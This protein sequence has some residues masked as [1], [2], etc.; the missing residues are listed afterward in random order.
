MI[1][2]RAFRISY[3]FLAVLGLL[4]AC[5]GG[6]GDKEQNEDSQIAPNPEF[7]RKAEAVSF[8]RIQLFEGHVKEGDRT[9]FE[10]DPDS[11]ESGEL[12][13]V[14]VELE[15]T[16]NLED[17]AVAIQLVPL[18]IFNQLDDGTTLGEIVNENTTIPAGSSLIDLGGAYID[19]IQPGL[20]HAVVHAKLPVLE[21]DSIFKVAV[22][23]SIGQ[24]S[25]GQEI[26]KDDLG[27][28]PVFFDDREL[29]ISKLDEVVVTIF[30]IPELTDDN[31]FTR[32]EVASGFDPEGFSNKP[33]FQTSL[34]VDITT[35]NESEEVVLSLAWQSPGGSPFP[36][37][38]LTSDDDGNPVISTQAHFKI[39]RTDTTS[40][41]IPVVAFTTETTH[42]ALLESA[43]SIRE[44]S[45]KPALSGNFT[46]A[47]GY[48]E[49]DEEVD[50]GN[51]FN[52]SI[53]L[54]SQ[55]TRAQVLAPEQIINFAVL[56][57]GSTNQACLAIPSGA[58]DIDTGFLGI[59]SVNNIIA[60]TCLS[61]PSDAMLWRY[62]IFTRQFISKETDENGDNYCLTAHDVQVIGN[63][64]ARTAEQIPF[65]NFVEMRLKKCE[66]RESTFGDFAAPGTALHEQTFEFEE[67][68]I[69][70]LMNNRY[71]TVTLL[72]TSREDVEL[73]VDSELAKDFSRDASGADVDPNGRLFFIG[74][75][76]E[77]GL[78]NV[79]KARVSLSYG[80]ESYL[81]YKPVLGTTT[82]GHATLSA[83]LFG[84]TVNLLD[85]SFAHKRYLSKQ[86]SAVAGNIHPV[87]VGNGAELKIEFLGFS[88][89]DLGEIET[90]TI[91]ESYNPIENITDM[92]S[93]EPNIT[94]ISNHLFEQEMDESFLQ[95]TFVVVAIPVT[96]EGGIKGTFKF[97][98][99]LTSPGIGIAADVKE[100]LNLEGYLSAKVDAIV[101][102]AGIEGEVE[103]INQQLTFI[104]GARFSA[105]TLDD[106]KLS[107]DIDSDLDL[108]LKLLKGKLSVFAEYPRVCLCLDVGET[109]RSDRVLYNSPHLFNADIEIFQGDG[110]FP[111]IDY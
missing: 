1:D 22:T 104:A 103:V 30:E 80:G 43:T 108:D 32:L 38:L 87:E 16:G 97:E 85:S 14:D 54:V 26:N 66:F 86:L 95:T 7:V 5:G 12:I 101:A 3:S 29:S 10:L 90:K 31:E 23:P 46:V 75:T 47:V 51:S 91:T 6:G 59:D 89:I 33:V 110:D 70:L 109:V 37:G 84:G 78:G 8:N 83:S 53:P 76:V 57:A 2:Y 60:S 42:E 56:R 111:I 93:S 71:L 39:D 21:Q 62:D 67:N 77:M 94:D 19:E 44:V 17:Y 102:S 50:T 49:N 63:R 88:A 61:S 13:T 40:I 73:I 96:V 18:S 58:F 11:L 55:D 24:L 82:E 65:G 34:E 15:I 74:D 72:G 9:L 36:L 45:S 35:F 4:T 68:K 25:V 48:I 52:L 41:T 69:M 27:T 99:K 64:A 105:D 79:D 20:L 106:T 107:F 28:M 100:T 98:S 92:L 81:D